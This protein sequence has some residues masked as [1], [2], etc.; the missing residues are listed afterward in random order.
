[1]AASSS[2]RSGWP[3]VVFD[4]NVPTVHVPARTAGE[5]LS[6]GQLEMEIVVV[7]RLRGWINIIVRDLGR[8]EPRS[9]LD[10]VFGERL[11]SFLQRG[12]PARSLSA[13]GL[14]LPDCEA[15]VKTC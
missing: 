15:T 10:Q 11:L 2:A 5:I 4:V 9:A 6:R 3:V 14:E 13:F 8:L 12:D 1:M 7:S